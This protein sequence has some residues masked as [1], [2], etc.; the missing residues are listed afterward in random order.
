MTRRAISDGRSTGCTIAYLQASK[1][2]RPI[3]EK[4]GFRVLEEY[5]E[6]K[7]KPRSEGNNRG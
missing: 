4:M 3:Y 1:M 5:S 2:G 6:W 7:T